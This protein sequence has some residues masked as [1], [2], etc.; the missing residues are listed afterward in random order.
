MQ[1]EIWGA[2]LGAGEDVGCRCGVQGGI[3]G[4]AQ[5]LEGS[6]GCRLSL[7]FCAAWQD[8]APAQVPPAHGEPTGQF[9]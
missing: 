2:D 4:A 7:L 8:P 9:H 6:L 3:W 1:E 5:G